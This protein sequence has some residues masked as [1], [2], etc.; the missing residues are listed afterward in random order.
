MVR[1]TGNM[2]NRK[3]VLIENCNNKTLVVLFHAYTSSPK[4]LKSV[5]EV[6]QQTLPDADIYT[7]KL[8][9]D[10]ISFI[11]PQEIVKVQ[12]LR[13]DEV[14]ENHYCSDRINRY[15]KIILV[16]H[17]FGALIARYLYIEA[18]AVN[19][20][21]STLK[22]TWST[23]V[24]RII[25]FAGMNR[26]WKI[27]H[28]LS[29]SNTV[30]W[31][32]GSIFAAS[33]W[34]LT[35][36]FPQIYAIKKG[37]PFI[38]NL[39]IRWIQ[40]RNLVDSHNVG[41]ALT[42]QLLG[43]IDD[44]VSPED[45]IDLVSGSDFIYIDVPH[46]G[47][48]NV[49]DMK[50]KIYGQERRSVFSK[51]LYENA[52][53]LKLLSQ[54]P[55]DERIEDKNTTITDV[56]FVMHGIRDLGYWTHK[57]ARRIIS[58][59]RLTKKTHKIIATETSSY[60]YFPMLSFLSPFKRMEKVS[61]LMDQYAEALARYPKAEFSF[62]GHSNGT[63]L[64]A[65]ALEDYP[66]CKFKNVVF[67]GS[68][69]RKDYDWNSKI[70]N[71]QVENVLNYV[72]SADW[73]VGFFPN[74][75]QKLRWQDLGSA[76]HDGFSLHSNIQQIRYIAGTHGAALHEN[77]WDAISD[78]VL[79]GKLT[80][81]PKELTKKEQSIVIKYAAMISPIIILILL[82][83]I[84]AV[85]YWLFGLSDFNDIQKTLLGCGLTYLIWKVMTK[86]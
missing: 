16:G 75:L 58:R 29:I 27:S 28:H 31:S 67:A 48:A 24:E 7:P 82:G 71:G 38:T 76:G 41:N 81:S 39:R 34:L 66:L 51:A 57:I 74:T 12:L 68:V 19:E 49:V 5:I 18:C 56:V 72:A 15:E 22:H 8:P 61:W 3:D 36:K 78:F 37:S 83:L 9:L 44:M 54:L 60:G 35:R 4:K 33:I 30:L 65:K 77:N 79:T 26:G 47:H 11:T 42:I 64:L 52:E 21:K 43:T 84:I 46:S 32:I 1:G 70:S 14:I 40:M 86:I 69:V 55:A 2:Q 6:I 13:I 10:F 50:H 25:L 80:P 85:Y 23:K 45:N 63:Y 59:S 20:D 62:V 53:N 73:V 17:S